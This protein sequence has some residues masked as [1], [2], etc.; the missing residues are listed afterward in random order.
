MEWYLVAE[1]LIVNANN[2][3]MELVSDNELCCG[4]SNR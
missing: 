3:V 4:T 2:S 1:V